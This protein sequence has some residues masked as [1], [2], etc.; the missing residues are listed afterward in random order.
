MM[1]LCGEKV[2]LA[3]FSLITIGSLIR[4]L[5]GQSGQYWGHS[6]G[7]SVNMLGQM[8]CF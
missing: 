4:G 2:E 3:H 1:I 7:W 6:A 8:K 5:S